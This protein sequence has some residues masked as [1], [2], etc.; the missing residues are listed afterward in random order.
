MAT[1][2]PSFLSPEIKSNAEKKLFNLFKQ[3]KGTEG[4]IVLHSLGISNHRTKIFGE[5]DFL[6]LAPR[7][8]LFALEV[9]G[10]RISRKDGIWSFTN[11]Y[12]ETNYSS[13]SPFDQARDG[14]FSVM[15]ALRTRRT[16]DNHPLENL[17]YGYGVMF[18]DIEFKS[19]YFEEDR[20][21]IFDVNNKSD[22]NSFI[23]NLARQKEKKLRQKHGEHYEVVRPTV[24]DIK[25]ISSILR[26]DFDQLISLSK[27]YDSVEKQLIKLTE[28]QYICLDQLED[29]SRCLI[30]GPA[31]TGKTLLAIEAAKRALSIG[32]KVGF[33][34]YNSNLGVFLEDQFSECFSNDDNLYVGTFHKFL[35]KYLKKLDFDLPDTHYDEFFFNKEL[36]EL[37]MIEFLM[38][39]KSCFDLI[40]LDEG[41]DLINSM[42]LD[43]FD[44]CLIKGF[45]RGKWIIFGDFSFQKIYNRFSN[46][47]DSIEQIKN[48]TAYID[49]K[50]TINCRNT[51]PIITEIDIFADV[52]KFLYSKRKID[53]PPVRYYNYKTQE[54]QIERVCSIVENLLEGEIRKKD[55]TILSPY[56]FENSVASKI[57]RYKIVEWEI[58]NESDITFSTIHSFKGLE[59]KIIIVVDL[60]SY[61]DNKLIYVGLSRAR[62]ALYILQTKEAR[63]EY[64]KLVEARL[65]KDAEEKRANL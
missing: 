22:L 24:K 38:R 32:K 54:E 9:K 13:R 53:G 18:P 10:G 64:N 45:N 5:I 42:N 28:E 50:L 26:P 3:G 17:L 55:I 56:R 1:M 59:N 23:V 33:F 15:D 51:I 11:R 60:D 63:K 58:N 36:P 57:E 47:N 39:G 31:G 34:C 29:N 12:D 20:Y 37:F 25:Y 65:L 21:Q 61:S 4:W 14:I 35:L 62:L 49:Y 2:I 27:K 30:H 8:G 6:V 7:L 43:I 48:R 19:E 16:L 44:L 40:I 46:E 41:Q 52:N